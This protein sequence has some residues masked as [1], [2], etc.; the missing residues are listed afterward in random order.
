MTGGET[1]GGF[2][3]YIALVAAY[4]MPRLELLA[5]VGVMVIASGVPLLYGDGPAVESLVNWVY[6]CAGASVVAV[7]LSKARQRLRLYAAT[8][9]RAALVDQ[10]TGVMN[11]RGFERHADA[12]LARAERSEASVALLYVDLDRFKLVK[13]DR[14]NKLGS[15]MQLSP[16][17]AAS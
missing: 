2:Y 8:A 15:S 9:G 5:I 1:Y 11:R 10:L 16:D 12:V 17:A 6:T 14:V 3:L 4:F 7:V 13:G